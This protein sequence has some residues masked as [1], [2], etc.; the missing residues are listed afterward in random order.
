MDYSAEGGRL[1]CWSNIG[2][3]CL[4]NQDRVPTTIASIGDVDL[5]AE[6]RR[7]LFE[8]R[9]GIRISITRDLRKSRVFRAA[10]DSRVV[11]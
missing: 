7:V 6:A 9:F 4:R 3:L 1:G 2:L 11:Y 5:D 10:C 8:K